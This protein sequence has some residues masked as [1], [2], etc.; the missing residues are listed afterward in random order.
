MQ[1][2]AQALERLRVR[3]FKSLRVVNCL[4]HFGG[5]FELGLGSRVVGVGNLRFGSWSRRDVSSG[6][7]VA[8][9]EARKVDGA[10]KK[11]VGRACSNVM[12]SNKSGDGSFHIS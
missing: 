8:R 9:C 1:L 2:A 6:S 4:R 10:R 12:F 5:C 11:G 3:L 7:D